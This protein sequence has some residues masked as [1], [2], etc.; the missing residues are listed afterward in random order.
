MSLKNVKFK[1][2]NFEV[3]RYYIDESVFKEFVNYCRYM[4]EQQFVT[5]MQIES[6]SKYGATYEFNINR[7]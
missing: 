7:Y 5:A 4:R 3:E 1:T 2:V 6:A